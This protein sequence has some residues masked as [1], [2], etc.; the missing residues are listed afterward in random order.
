MPYTIRE[1]QEI[2]EWE[3]WLAEGCELLVLCGH[4]VQGIKGIYGRRTVKLIFGLE[5]FVYK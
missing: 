2:R 3:L 4:E 1:V 5:N